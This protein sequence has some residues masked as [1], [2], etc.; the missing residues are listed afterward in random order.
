VLGQQ[1][2]SRH[3]FDLNRASLA[4]IQC[5]VGTAAVCGFATVDCS[6]VVAEQSCVSWPL[7][8]GPLG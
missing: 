2:G 1:L 8:P 5:R 3:G 7:A 6:G 4:V